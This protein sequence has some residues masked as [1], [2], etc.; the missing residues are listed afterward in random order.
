M[1]FKAPSA[2]IVEAVLLDLAKRTTDSVAKKVK[3]VRE[4]PTNIKALEKR[5]GALEKGF[6]AAQEAHDKKEE[7]RWKA[8]DVREEAGWQA[9]EHHYHAQV[10]HEDNRPSQPKTSKVKKE[11]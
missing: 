2:R 3:E 5:L 6:E 1:G 11:S 9:H 8:H 7:A 4:L 10:R